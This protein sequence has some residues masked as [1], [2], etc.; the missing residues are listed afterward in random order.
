M[1]TL[2]SGLCLAALTLLVILLIPGPNEKRR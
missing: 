2:L 1:E